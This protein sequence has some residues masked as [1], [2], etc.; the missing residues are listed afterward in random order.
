MGDYTFSLTENEQNSWCDCFQDVSNLR[1]KKIPAKNTLYVNQ[2][3]ERC[4]K[5]CNEIDKHQFFD[6]TAMKPCY[7]VS[8]TNSFNLRSSY[9]RHQS[10]INRII[11]ANKKKQTNS[12]IVFE[13]GKEISVALFT[14]TQKDVIKAE[15]RKIE[16]FTD[17]ST[18]VILETLKKSERNHLNTLIVLENVIQSSS[19]GED[20]LA[21]YIE[22]SL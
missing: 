8:T 15:I 5:I 12:H 7:G 14:Q 17:Y 11:L 21:I 13:N 22:S 2:E 4:Q 6:A 9:L 3:K 1:Y 10:S 19:N 18:P 20:Q 16:N